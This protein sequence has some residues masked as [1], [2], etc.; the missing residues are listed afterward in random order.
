MADAEETHEELPAWSMPAAALADFAGR[1]RL[2]GGR[3]AGVGVRRLDGRG[4]ARVRRRQRRRRAPAGRRRAIGRGGRAGRRGR[5]AR[6]ARR[7][8]RPLRARQRLR[9]RDPLASRP[10]ARST[11][12]ACS[13]RASAAT[14]RSCSKGCGSALQRA[15]RRHQPEP[16]DDQRRVAGRAARADRS[17]LLPALADRG[18]RAQH[19]GRVVPLAVRERDQRRQPR[20]ARRADLVRESRSAGGAVRA[21][22]RRRGRLAGRRDDHATGNSF[23][24][25]HITGICALI[26]AKHPTLTPAA[27]KHLLRLLADNTRTADD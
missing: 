22:R 25:P 17:G 19:A 26:R 4:R 7:R 9:G 14:A 10:T 3:H 5:V 2:A 12:C 16:L 27:V 6:R 24:T 20:P 15:L 1:L 18:L 8:G 23:A 13:G 21:R 11:A